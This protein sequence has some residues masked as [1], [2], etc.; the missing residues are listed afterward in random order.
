MGGGRGGREKMKC[1]V[2]EFESLLKFFAKSVACKF[3]TRGFIIIPV[4]V[5]K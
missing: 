3:L 4:Y 2:F 1:R 5:T